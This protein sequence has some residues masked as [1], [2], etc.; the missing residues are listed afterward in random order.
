[1]ALHSARSYLRVNIRKSWKGGRQFNNSSSSKYCNIF[2]N[3]ARDRTRSRSSSQDPKRKG[4]LSHVPNNKY[5]DWWP[6]ANIANRGISCLLSMGSI[7]SLRILDISEEAYNKLF[8]DNSK[9]N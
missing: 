3:T 5:G 7:T 2:N 1:M 6:K 8:Q 9:R 4:H